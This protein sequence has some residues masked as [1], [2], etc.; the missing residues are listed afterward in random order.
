MSY[1]LRNKR[2]LLTGGTGTFGRAF[3]HYALAAGVKELRVF[4]RDE[5]KQYEMGR[6]IP[7]S[8]ITYACGDVRDLDRVLE[9]SKSV[10]IVVHAAAMKRLE[11]C[12]RL[13][14]EAIKTNVLG[15]MNVAKAAIA[16]R[17]RHAIT[18]SSD[19]AVYPVNAYGKTK[20]LMENVWIQSNDDFE[21]D[22][23][24]MFSVVRYGNVI[25][26]RG[27]VVDIFKQQAKEGCVK[28]TNGDM[29][30]FFMP[31]SYATHLVDFA[32]SC[33]QGGEI[34]VPFLKASSIMILAKAIADGKPIA[35]IDPRPGE[36]VHEDIITGKEKTRAYVQD[37]VVVI[38]PE[39]Y[40]WPYVLGSREHFDFPLTSRTAEQLTVE[41]I[42]SLIANAQSG[43][44]S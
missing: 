42:K 36:K 5:L 41:E 10:D 22:H 14:Q 21:E 27:S 4:S 25:G 16:N 44:K 24:T 28:V 31:V 17:V 37:G 34:F 11:V 39:S 32:I 15:S 2:V 8:R 40:S 7:D 33:Q 23:V 18:L 43:I 35:S 19:K 30:R 9:V 3:T 26:S 38:D 6:D 29:T 1:S 12:E 13:P 20:A